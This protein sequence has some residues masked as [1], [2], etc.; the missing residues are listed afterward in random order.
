MNEKI[1]RCHCKTHLI[2]V[3]KDE[4]EPRY[5]IILY[6]MFDTYMELSQYAAD[7]YKQLCN[8]LG[9]LRRVNEVCKNTV[10]YLPEWWK[11]EKEYLIENGVLEKAAA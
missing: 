3:T 1:I 7:A 10:E 9:A 6:E 4:E 8:I 2:E 5:S 11:Q